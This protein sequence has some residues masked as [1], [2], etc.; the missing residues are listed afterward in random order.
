M[1]QF[2]P[3]QIE[4][5]EAFSGS[6]RQDHPGFKARL[7]PLAALCSVNVTNMLILG[8]CRVDGLHRP[9]VSP[10]PDGEVLCDRVHNAICETCR[11]L[12]SRGI[13]GPFES[14]RAAIPYACLWGDIE[15][16]AGITVEEGSTKSFRRWEPHPHSQNGISRASGSAPAREDDGNGRRVAADTIARSCEGG[17]QLAEAADRATGR[18]NTDQRIVEASV[19]VLASFPSVAQM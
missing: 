15:R 2:L 17:H 18:K 10:V 19:E 14:W 5:G 7:T 9:T 3:Q 1:P 12:M 11:V 8:D 4:S 16:T 6:G 13:T